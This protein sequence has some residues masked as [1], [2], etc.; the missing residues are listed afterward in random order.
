MEHLSETELIEYVAGKLSTPGNERVE[1]HIATCSEC[2]D[3]RREV[4]KTWGTLGQWTIDTTSHNI[5]EKVTNAAEKLKNQQEQHKYPNILKAGF[6]P[7]M[8]RIAASIV[9]A[10]GIGHKLGRYSVPQNKPPAA[11]SQNTPNYLST[12]GLEWSSELAWL[13][14]E[15][16]LPVEQ[17]GQG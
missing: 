7:D 14:I 2:S 17:E 6:W 16:E 11:I 13:I 3:R 5:A 1:Q 15:D 8:L 9:I 4:T 12:L 10:A